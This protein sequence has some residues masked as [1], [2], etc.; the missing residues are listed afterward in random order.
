M[1]FR[2][3]TKKPCFWSSTFLSGITTIG[4]SAFGLAMLLSG[5][6]GGGG[7]GGGGSGG[8]TAPPRI[9]APPP[10]RPISGSAA[11]ELANTPS[12]SLVRASAIYSGDQRGSGH[13]IGVVD[14][15]VDANHRELAGRVIGGGDWQDSREDGRV[16][17]S[18]HGTHVAS[19][20]AAARDRTGMHG[21]V[22][23]AKIVS[24]RIL[25]AQGRFGSRSGN[26]MIPAI[27]GDVG[28][29]NLKVVNNSWASFNEINDFS[30]FSI[31][32]RLSQELVAYRR[33]ASANGPMMVW[34]AGNGG[35]T[36]V[37]IR[38]G[39]PHYFPE[40][41][42]NW[43]TVVAVDQNG[44]EPTY[45]NRCG[46]SSEWC[47][48]APGGGDN[49]RVHGVEA[50]QSGGGYTRRSG[51][52]MAAPI[53]S[54]ALTLLMEAMPNLSPRQA[55]VRLKATATYEGLRSA[56]G[57]TVNTCTEAEMRNIFGHGLIQVEAALQPIGA[58][59]IIT[60]SGQNN[61]APTTYIRTPGLLGDSLQ[62]AL[63]GATAVV[64]DDFDQAMFLTPL[65][66]RILSADDARPELSPEYT[67][68][69]A[70]IDLPMGLVTSFAPSAPAKHD[71]PAKLIDIP[72]AKVDGWHGVRWSGQEWQGRMMLGHGESRQ[73]V[74]VLM[75]DD[76]AEDSAR[77]FGGGIDRNEDFLDGAS[78]GG[79]DVD[80][81]SS[82]WFFAGQSL[83]LGTYE[84]TAEALM[85]MTSL[86]PSSGS[87]ISSGEAVYDSWSVKL[88]Q[89]AE[90]M[91]WGAIDWGVQIEQPPALRSGQ[92]TLDQP[93]QL[94]HD[95]VNFTSRR[96]DLK[97]PARELRQTIRFAKALLPQ[98]KLNLALHH[99]QNTGHKLGQDDQALTLSFKQQF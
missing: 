45:T 4:L 28:A 66:V 79:L 73:A 93:T 23:D 92:I 84:M 36:E 44:R 3:Y 49:R 29:R 88:D 82:R 32:H 33:R 75:T 80:Q 58:A 69:S 87:L 76:T 39:L 57:C 68:H 47:L 16:D 53:V 30:A 38:G 65:D 41:K 83:S 48:T 54:G 40:L 26:D 9:F 96:Y 70:T 89:Q 27:L 43:L 10:A 22:P 62:T 85:G 6:G 7:G 91:N 51:T 2:L 25:N 77:W 20:I 61:P 37:S 81:S 35:A 5:C 13:E 11:S 12:L 86:T 95:G 1:P 18:G 17:L 42:D 64:R 14:S 97:L 71:S 55:A 94:S 46:L 31:Q 52:S 24:Y 67:D 74:H 59:S 78:S 98:S 15:G 90:V 50:A 56:R 8:V 34:A 19:I 99:I 63:D 60:S 21:I 72:T